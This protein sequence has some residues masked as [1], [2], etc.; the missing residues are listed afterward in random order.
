MDLQQHS[1][2]HQPFRRIAT[3]SDKDPSQPNNIEKDVLKASQLIYEILGR[4]C[5]GIRSPL[6]YASGLQDEVEVVNA[7]LR[8][9]IKYISSD[10][11]DKNWSIEPKLVE[12]GKLRQPY[13]YQDNLLEFPTHDWQDTAFTGKSKTIGV[14]DYPTTVQDIL[15]YFINLTEHTRDLSKKDN[16]EI[17]IGLCLHPQAIN[18]Y[19]P[20]LEFHAKLLDYT[21]KN[22]ILVS[23]YTDAYERMITLP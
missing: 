21:K 5:I 7:L 6:G 22:G 8:T 15:E 3:K 19:D 20:E 18:V 10:L 4:E 12:D 14:K 13:F 1:S 11:R 23:S 9:G 16:K 17:Y 2:S